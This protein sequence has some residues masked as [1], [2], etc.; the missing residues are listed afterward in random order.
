VSEVDAGSL[1]YQPTFTSLTLPC[2][3]PQFSSVEGRRQTFLVDGISLPR[4]QSIDVLVDAGFFHVGKSK[5][6]SLDSV[7]SVLKLNLSNSYEN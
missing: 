5:H 1:H 2:K 4:G 6:V 7:G 3:Y